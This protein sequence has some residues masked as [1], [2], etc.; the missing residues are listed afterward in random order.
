[1]YRMLRILV[2]T[3]WNIQKAQKDMNIKEIYR[4]RR[5]LVNIERTVQNAQNTREY[6]VDIQNAL[7]TSKY[8]RNQYIE[9]LECL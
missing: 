3:T 5:I 8:E 7:K 2:N 6:K 4:M 1:M 9:C